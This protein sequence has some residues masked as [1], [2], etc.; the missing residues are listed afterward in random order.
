V[1]KLAERSQA[2]AKEISSLASNSVGVAEHSGALLDELVPSILKTA[3]LVQEVTA[4]SREQASG[5]NQINR[6]MSQVDQV[7]QR[8]ASSAEE[9]SS[10]A[11]EMASQAEALTQL[12][13]FFKTGGAEPVF[14]FVRQHETQTAGP[15]YPTQR[16]QGRT[17]SAAWTGADGSK[18][19]NGEDEH[20][21]ARFQ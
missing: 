12:M 15:H 16:H 9:L 3:E 21:F 6:A 14:S 10:T 2:A 8:N 20:G 1:R 19:R 17:P 18:S 13:A 5:V 11:E 7:T 4:A